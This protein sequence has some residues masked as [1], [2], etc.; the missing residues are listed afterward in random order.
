[1]K[2]RVLEYRSPQVTIQLLDYE[3]QMRISRLLFER[4]YQTGIYEVVN[5]E[6]LPRVF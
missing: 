5:P 4:R 1:M 6:V 3:K 2:V